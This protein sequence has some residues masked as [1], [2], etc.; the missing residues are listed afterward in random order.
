M[1]TSHFPFLTVLVLVPAVGA[2]VVALVPPAWS[3][4]WFHE[5]VGA[6]VGLFT[7]VLAVVIVGVSSRSTTAATRWSPTT[8]GPSQL[9][10]HW[11]LGID[12][13]SLFLV[14]MTACSSRWPCSGPG[15]GGTPGP[16]WPGCSCWRRRAW[17]A[18]S[19]STWCSS[20]SSSS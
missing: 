18:S 4:A 10:I 15:P 12:G 6:L 17:A 3:P 8:S 9:G 13:I 20:S 1:A 11:S 5:A 14:V 19:P 16:S 2:A 7:L